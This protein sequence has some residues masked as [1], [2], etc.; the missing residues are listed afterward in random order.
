MMSRIER[1]VRDERGAGTVEF[2]FAA[3][4]L[5]AFI[6]GVA[7]LG[8]FF[9]ANA[10]LRSAV[11]EGA[12]MATLFPRPSHAEIAQAVRNSKFG[13]DPQHISEPIVA[14][15]T[16]NGRPFLNIRM[17]YDAP[18][19]FIFFNLGSVTLVENRGVYL[20]AVP[21]AASTSSSTSSTSTGGTTTTSSSSTGGDD[22]AKKNDKCK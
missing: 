5:F 7:Q 17:Q 3:P 11:A 10:G 9:F 16:R 6:I 2:A 15:T 19:N 21:V 1:A 13:L 18:M 8:T 20:N 4:I 14:E 12:R 22:C